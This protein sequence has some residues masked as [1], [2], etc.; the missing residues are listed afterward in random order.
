MSLTAFLDQ[1]D[2]VAMVKPLRPTLPRKIDAPLK[3]EPHSDHHKMVGSAFD[4][5]LRFELQRRAPHAV[6]ETWVA[7]DGCDRLWHKDLETGYEGGRDLLK[8]IVDPKDYLPPHEVGRR[9]RAIVEKA[10]FAV[11]SFLKTRTPT[12]AQ[13]S[14]LAAHAIR[15][16]KLD[17]VARELQLDPRFEEAE[18]EDVEDLLNLLEIV[19]FGSLLH[20]KTMLLN[21]TF[22]ESSV[23]VGG[24]DAD[25]IA[26]DLLVDF[27]VTKM[28]RMS[29]TNLDQLLGY[30]LLARNHRQADPTF[31]EIKRVALYFS[32]HGLLWPL[33]VTVWTNHPGF[34]EVETWFFKRARDAFNQRVESRERFLKQA[35]GAIKGG[36]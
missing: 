23:L 31:P 11:D 25:L 4:Y 29:A 12:R 21:P 13:L 20:K 18:G 10:K 32:R 7:E 22:G 24:A 26:G 19:P 27:K 34:P 28:G 8:D 35:R 30:Y 2:V 36:R 17:Q 9:A 5:F 15:L 33:D 16:A 3:V 6:T 1:P 14:E